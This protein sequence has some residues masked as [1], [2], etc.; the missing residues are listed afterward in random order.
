MP[1]T[2]LERLPDDARVWVFG[3][4]P[5]LNAG[6][7]RTL[8]RQV[9][10]FLDAWSAHGTPISSARDLRAGT[11]LIIAVDKSAETS[12]CSIDRLYGTLQQLERHFGVSILDAGRIFFRHGDDRIDAMT[13]A[14]F[15]EKGDEHTIVFDTTTERLSEIRSGG[16]ERPA[17]RSWHRN[18]LRRAG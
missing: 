13:R 18:L 16:W 8:L 7:S 11:F 10:E 6:Q 5:T 2:E 17:S 4:S 15:R 9:D 14:E 3:I 1:R 12:G